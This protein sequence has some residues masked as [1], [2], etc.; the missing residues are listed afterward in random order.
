MII[1]ADSP[2]APHLMIV[3]RAALVGAVKRIDT[4]T[5]EYVRWAMDRVPE[6]DVLGFATAIILDC[7]EVN[8]PADLLEQCCADPN[9][10]IVDSRER[11]L[12]LY[13]ELGVRIPGVNV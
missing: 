7:T 13:D 4:E 1:D 9:V 2:L 11:L 5:K 8:L 3:R 10:E 12:E 6:G